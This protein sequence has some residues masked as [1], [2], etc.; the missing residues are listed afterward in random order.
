[1]AEILRLLWMLVVT[2]G[3]LALAYLVTRYIAGHQSSLNAVYKGRRMEVLER[4]SLSREQQLLLIRL[5]ESYYYAGVSHGGITLLKE[6]SAEEAEALREKGK[7]PP[8]PELPFSTILQR[9][10]KKKDDGKEGM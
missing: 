7:Q 10:M 4:L 5:G 3:I 1:M 2:I 8:M 9:V 6:V